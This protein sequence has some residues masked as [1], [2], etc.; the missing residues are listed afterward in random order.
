M[1]VWRRATRRLGTLF[2]TAALLFACDSTSPPGPLPAPDLA[3]GTF[4]AEIRGAVSRD[5]AGA[6]QFDFTEHFVS[7]TLAAPT[8]GEEVHLTTS[9]LAE[10][11]FLY[12]VGVHHFGVLAPVIAWYSAS[13]SNADFFA[14]VSG[15]LR[16]YERTA[17]SVLARIDVTAITNPESGPQRQVRIVGAFHAS[18]AAP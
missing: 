4:E 18:T 2:A 7:V 10:S 8:L 14:V 17:T 6:A 13:Q 9:P 12:P 3:L 11:P 1:S 5:I 16:V 15:E